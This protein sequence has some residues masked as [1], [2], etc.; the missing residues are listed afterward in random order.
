MPKTRGEQESPAE[1]AGRGVFVVFEGID[2]AGTSTQAERYAAH[3]RAA[4]RLVH[5]TREPSAGPVGALLR[6]VLTHRISLPG[7]HQ[8]E[9]M[10]L[11]FSA[12]RLDHLGAEI[13]P[14]L[15]DGYVVISDRYDLSSLAYQSTTASEDGGRSEEIIE[16]IRELNRHALRPDVTVVIDV[17][18]EI[19]EKRRRGRGGAEELFEKTELQARLAEAYRRAEELVPG[20]R[21]IHIDGDG[22]VDEVSRAITAALAAVVER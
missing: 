9:I 13:E 5:V 2:G 16:W 6:Q 14:L 20:D 11:L 12:D 8:A 10:A 4:R 15:R 17:T 3:L 19:A 18:P 21:I 22:P 1:E 7:A